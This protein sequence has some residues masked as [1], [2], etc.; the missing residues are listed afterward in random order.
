MSNRVS[1][2]K[3]D[4]QCANLVEKAYESHKKLV[5]M[6]TECHNIVVEENSLVKSVS[7]FLTS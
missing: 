2:E 5:Q 3:F 1:F 7:L 6:E 4:V